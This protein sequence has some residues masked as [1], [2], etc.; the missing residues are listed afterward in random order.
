MMSCFSGLW[1]AARRAGTAALAVLAG[2]AAGEAGAL[3]IGAIA[4]E[5]GCGP[6]GSGDCFFE[7]GLGGG[8][9]SSAS[10]QSV[11]VES[12]LGAGLLD[13]VA[14]SS[15]EFAASQRLGSQDELLA[16][17][18]DGSYTVTITFTDSSV[19]SDQ[20]LFAPGQAPTGGFE[21]LSATPGETFVDLIFQN[22]CPNCLMYSQGVGFDPT[23]VSLTL[24]NLDDPGSDPRRELVSQSTASFQFDSLAQ[25]THY[26][27]QTAIASLEFSTPSFDGMPTN[28]FQI[29]TE[30]RS[31]QFMTPEPSPLLLLGAG[32]GALALL[33]R[34]RR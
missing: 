33:R 4:F 31:T 16:R 22:Q 6:G 29:S 19:V 13:L 23:S 11:R 12:D 1:R 17:F 32:L 27:L 26:E 25:R 8:A 14:I 30:L 5:R 7:A 15:V 10:V 9:L 24:T 34:R 28:Y 20:L 21:I 18:P 2:L 3:Q